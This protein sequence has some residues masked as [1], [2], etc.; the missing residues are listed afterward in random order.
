MKSFFIVCCFLLCSLSGIASTVIKGGVTDASN[1]EGIIGASVILN[2]KPDCGAI[3]D[4]DGNFSL[5]IPD[6]TVFPV[7]VTVNYIG[8]K[9]VS[10]RVNGAADSPVAIRMKSE[11]ITMDEVMVTARRKTNSEAG[12]LTSTRLSTSVTSGI[13]GGQIAK[14]ADSDAGEAVKRIPGVSLIDGRYIIV[15]GL[16]QRYNNVWINGGVAPSS[17]EESVIGEGV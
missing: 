2:G 12:I 8:Y 9:E 17:D 15:R 16:S 11:D 14:T 7:V 13:S 4:I 5:S 10:M 6:G 1:G 3:T